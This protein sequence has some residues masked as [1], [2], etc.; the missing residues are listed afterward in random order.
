MYLQHTSQSYLPY[1]D[2]QNH[3]FLSPA[4]SLMGTDDGVT[5]SKTRAV[6]AVG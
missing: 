6:G 2:Y 1:R 4:N 3:A 5:M